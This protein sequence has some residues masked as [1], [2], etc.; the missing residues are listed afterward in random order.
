MIYARIRAG[1]VD[2]LFD[3]SPEQ[4]AALVLNGKAQY[5]RLWVVDP[6]P[7]PSATQVVVEGPVVIT[8]TEAKRTWVLREKT[9]AEADSELNAAETAL[10]KQAVAELTTDIQAYNA[11]PD[12]SGTTVQVLTKV[13]ARLRDVER[14]MR[15][16]NRILR[17]Y[18]RSLA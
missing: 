11:N 10:L 2:G 1:N 14:Q 15:R 13:E 8:E 4:Y 16:N 5:L 7:V 9:Q 17:Y 6:M 3:L 18:L 12:V